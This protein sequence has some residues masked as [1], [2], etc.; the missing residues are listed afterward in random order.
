[1]KNP[2][3]AILKDM[4]FTV[5]RQPEAVPSSEAAHA[6]LLFAHVA[7]NRRA[8]TRTPDYR[9]MLGEFEASNP[10]L[11]AELIST[12]PEV[13]IAQLAVYRERHHR[14][15]HRYVVVCGMRD[16]QVHAEWTDGRLSGPTI[17]PAPARGR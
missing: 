4:A 14:N 7:W 12:D 15:D 9:P 1:M 5:L 6:A 13:M 17:G 10:D 16:E 8:D 11:W 2:L 3:S